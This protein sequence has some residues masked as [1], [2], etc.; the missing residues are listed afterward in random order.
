LTWKARATASQVEFWQNSQ[1][2]KIR[3]TCLEQQTQKL[4]LNHWIPTSQYCQ[5]KQKSEHI[6]TWRAIDETITAEE[7]EGPM[8]TMFSIKFDNTNDVVLF[9]KTFIDAQKFNECHSEQS[10]FQGLE[11]S[12]KD[13]EP[14]K[15]EVDNEHAPAN[16]TID[17][18]FSQN[19][20]A[21]LSFNFNNNSKD[22]GDENTEEM[23]QRTMKYEQA[24][25]ASSLLGNAGGDQMNSGA[26]FQFD[27]DTTSVE[28]VSPLQFK[29]IFERKKKKNMQ[30]GVDLEFA[31][32]IPKADVSFGMLSDTQATNVD[33]Q[34]EQPNEHA[35]LSTDVSVYEFIEED[36]PGDSKPSASTREKDNG[37]YA[38]KKRAYS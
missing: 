7:K 36:Q 9:Q 4:R 22:N 12:S 32:D 38:L 16:T 18:S 33:A 34:K 1:V 13:K 3:I 15:R 27:V 37:V 31:Q 8:V 35:Q 23:R 14:E 20:S 26:A 24:Q 25:K 30:S 19:Q 29:V 17:E 28:I 6:L 21:D 2:G 5:L 10:S 11:Q